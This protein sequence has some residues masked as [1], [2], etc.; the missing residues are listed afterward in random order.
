MEDTAE[1]QP[2]PEQID[3]ARRRVMKRVDELAD[4]L[5]EAS[6][7]IHGHPELG[8]EEHFATIYSRG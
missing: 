6:H 3:E 2:S 8:Y 1:E 5:I 7:A 4:V